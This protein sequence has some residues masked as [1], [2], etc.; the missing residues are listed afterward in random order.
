MKKL[1]LPLALVAVLFTSC[2]DDDSSMVTPEPEPIDQTP[3]PAQELKLV[4]TS[5]TSGKIS[6]T[7]LLATTPLQK[8][9][10]L[11]QQMQMV[12]TM[13]HLKIK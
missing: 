7:D 5:N 1:F 13:I 3:T 10:Q 12:F 8:V 11:V 9:L 2:N 4:T 6:F